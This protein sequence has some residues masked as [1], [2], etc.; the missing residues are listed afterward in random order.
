MKQ[1]RKLVAVLHGT[2]ARLEEII[3]LVGQNSE[4]Y[5]VTAIDAPANAR[6][7]RHAMTRATAAELGSK[8]A[9]RY[10]SHTLCRIGLRDIKTASPGLRSILELLAEWFALQPF[11]R[12]PV[13]RQL[14]EAGIESAASKITQLIDQ[15]Y[16]LVVGNGKG[17][18]LGLELPQTGAPQ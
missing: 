10:P 16:L 12:T 14:T 18:T 4:T 2:P 15:G 8:T 13:G 9:H 1:Y 11:D 5:T 7:H 3:S 6:T 17:E